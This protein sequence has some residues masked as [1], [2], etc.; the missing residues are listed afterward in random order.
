MTKPSK[1]TENILRFRFELNVNDVA[2]FGSDSVLKTKMTLRFHRKEIKHRLISNQ[3]SLF[4]MLP[5]ETDISFNKINCWMKFTK[6][7][8]FILILFSKPLLFFALRLTIDCVI[9]LCMS[10]QMLGE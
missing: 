2:I 8:S 7:S 3:A 6:E 1:T 4:Q 9:W 5:T 10:H